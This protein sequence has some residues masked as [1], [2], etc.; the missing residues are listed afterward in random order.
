MSYDLGGRRVGCEMNGVFSAPAEPCS[1]DLEIGCWEWRRRSAQ[2]LK[3]GEDA[4][5]GD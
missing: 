1:T 2:G 4:G 3:E 5:L